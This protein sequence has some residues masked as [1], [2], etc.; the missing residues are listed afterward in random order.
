MKSIILQSQFTGYRP[1]KDKSCAITFTSDL[2]VNSEQ[3][4]QFHELLD[5]RGIVYFSVKGELT[6][7]EIDEIDSVDIELE[8]KS[9]SQ[10]LRAVLYILW[11]QSGSIGDFKNFYSEWMEKIIQGIK[12]KLDG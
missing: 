11:E 4:K 7:A 1:K 12:D 10:R 2:E 9:K 8:G 3:I 5:Q 6:Q